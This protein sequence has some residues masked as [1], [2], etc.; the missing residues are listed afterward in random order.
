M[1]NDTR[2]RTIAKPLTPALSSNLRSRPAHAL[3]PRLAG[4][5]PTSPVT[6]SLRSLRQQTI[7]PDRS[8]QERALSLNSNI[9]PRSGARISR[10]ETDSPSTPDTASKTRWASID[11]QSA[12]DS[13][14]SHVGLGISSPSSTPTYVRQKSI[15]QLSQLPTA[16]GRRIS[17]GSNISAVKDEAKFFRADEIK[18]GNNANGMARPKSTYFAPSNLKLPT[19]KDVQDKGSPLSP[20][21]IDHV[22]RIPATSNSFKIAPDTPSVAYVQSN[23]PQRPKPSVTMSYQSTS[24][25]GSTANGSLIVRESSNQSTNSIQ[26]HSDRR[27]SVS[28]NSA[29]SENKSGSKHYKSLSTI[30]LHSPIAQ[31]TFST[32]KAFNPRFDQLN[33]TSSVSN[34]TQTESLTSTS[35]TV[36]HESSRSGL[37]SRHTRGSS[38]AT[39]PTVNKEQME[40]ASNARRERKVLDLEISNSSLLAINRTLEKELRKQNTEL[41]RFRRL[42]QS[43]R[44]SLIPSSRMVSGASILSLSTLD[45]NDQDITP[46]RISPASSDID[47]LEDEEDSDDGSSLTESSDILRRRARDEKRLLQDLQRHQQILIDSQ[48]LT[49][50]IQRCLSCTDELIKEGNKALSYQVE[51]SEIQI[52][53]RVLQHDDDE[54]LS[55]VDFDEYREGMQKPRQ[56]LLSPITTKTGL[57]EATMWLTGLKSLNGQPVTQYAEPV[58]DNELC[59]VIL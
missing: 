5:T 19:R 20:R 1:P 43:G 25:S 57:E 47:S 34:L 54:A 55:E 44:L 35:T 18:T 2:S 39:I 22:N 28:I 51:E 3:T 29:I 37:Q 58:D 10:Y 26:T 27:R 21:T 32:I 36:S 17:G 53:G 42:S 9:T 4:I 49:Q 15:D 41:R 33:T 23:P 24:L 52:G 8:D 14:D 13:I 30:S 7:P 40:A 31:P 6:T 12:T 56:G 45:E 59:P 38:E 11:G 50:S 48:K 16:N 46:S